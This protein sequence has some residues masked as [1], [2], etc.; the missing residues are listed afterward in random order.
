MPIRL[1]SLNIPDAQ[2]LTF[3]E[4]DVHSTLFEPDMQALGFPPRTSSQADGEYF[5][6]QRTLAV[7]RLRSLTSNAHRSTH[8]G[9]LA[10]SA[11]RASRPRSRMFRRSNSGFSPGHSA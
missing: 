10:W 8:S 9:A 5:V 2:K 7:R 4:A 3:S 6:E 11:S 1:P